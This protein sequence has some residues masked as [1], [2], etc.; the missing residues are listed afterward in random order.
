MYTETENTNSTTSSSSSTTP[1]ELM[2]PELAVAVDQAEAV[3]SA[4]HQD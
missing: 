3:R 2:A 4:C 1:V